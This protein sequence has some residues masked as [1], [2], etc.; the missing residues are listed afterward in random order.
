MEGSH[1]HLIGIGGNGM[2][3]L[4]DVLRGWGWSVS[5]SD[6]MLHGHAAENLPLSTDLVIH[7]DAIPA[8]NPELLRAAELGLPVS[9]YFQVLGKI[10]QCGTGFQPVE[11]NRPAGNLRNSFRQVGNVSHMT[12]AVAG[13]H[14]K[15][16]VTAMAGHILAWCGRN[17]TVFCGA[18]PIGQ[19]SGGRAGRRD[20][21][22]VE[23][24]E[25]RKNFLNLRPNQAV[26]LNIEPDHFDCY[27]NLAQLETAFREFAESLPEDGL[28]LIREDC[29][30]TKRVVQNLPCGI[31]TFGFSSADWT[32]RDI[33]QVGG[34]Y[35]FSVFKEG[36]FFTAVRL[37]VPGRHNLANAL[38]A[39]AICGENG[40]SGEE[41]RQGL[42]SFPGL[43]RRFEICRTG[44]QPVLKNR[45][46]GNLSYVMDYA[47]HPTEVMAALV[48]AREVFT[49]RRIWCIFQPHQVSRTARLLDEF[50]ESLQ[51]ADKIAVAEIFRARE[52]KQKPG[53]VTAS[54][55]AR[56][57][58]EIA[59]N[60]ANG[61]KLILAHRIE[62]IADI[63]TTQVRVDDV[64]ITLGAGDIH[65]KMCLRLN[66]V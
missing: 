39:T 7:S 23:A 41:I 48:T 18:T 45:Q 31:K 59:G 54:D 65:D 29:S 56:R 24:C 44:F 19:N 57:I 61:K 13:T 5:G 63:L 22:V 43:Q 58:A 53:E 20:F 50:A 12:L 25:Y 33:E 8:D 52:G 1:A 37:P 16:T 4:A 21:F 11:K 6:M 32:A 14:G 60:G 28:L 2:R 26:I 51:N 49:N 9:S 27:E 55:L 30:T 64:I 35:R 38:A 15:S 3:A 10:T 62:E 34:F 36:K 47:H 17:P 40:A 66:D 42:E 46:V